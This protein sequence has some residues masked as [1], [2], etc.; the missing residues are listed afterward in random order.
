MEFLSDQYQYTRDKID[1][2][3]QEI[4][5]DYKKGLIKLNGGLTTPPKKL[6]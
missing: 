3:Q 1:Y 2:V 4:F 6:I 5:Y